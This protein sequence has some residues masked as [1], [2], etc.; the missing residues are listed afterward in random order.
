M[1]FGLQSLIC[2]PGDTR[3]P[4]NKPEKANAKAI[5]GGW[6]LWE[7]A[8]IDASKDWPAPSCEQFIQQSQ[9]P[10]FN[11]DALTATYAQSDVAYEWSD[12][13]QFDRYFVYNGIVMDLAPY[14]D[15]DGNFHG[16]DL[17][18]K[19]ESG[20]K[21]VTR[22]VYLDSGLRSQMECLAERYRV[23]YMSKDS[24]GCFAM[25]V[26]NAVAL[27]MILG[28][29][30]LRFSMALIYTLFVAPKLT[31]KPDIVP[32]AAL[33][34]ALRDR[35]STIGSP[36]PRPSF[37]V[38][39]LTSDLPHAIMLVTCYSENEASLRSTFDSV[40]ATDYDDSQK[41][42]F[43]VADGQIECGETRDGK[44]LLTSEICISM[45]ELDASCAHPEPKPYVAVADGSKQKNMAQVVRPLH[46]FIHYKYV[47]CWFLSFGRTPRSGS[48]DSQVRHAGGTA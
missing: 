11:V 15:R 10:L 17:K 36:R 4:Y 38:P 6:Y 2:K 40:V 43:I 19:I 37:Q 5:R 23:G 29:V 32:A 42:L 41:L 22:K 34:P 26:I 35:S 7:G 21:D 20:G 1:T 16:D 45:L 30:F 39:A 47:V 24:R 25:T 33:P 3:W 9:S 28:L 18:A 48:V 44:P 27:V 13:D 12:L 8:T 14:F 31:R 46:S